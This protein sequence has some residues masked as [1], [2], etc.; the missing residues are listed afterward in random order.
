M[1]V[2]EP[3]ILVLSSVV[4]SFG[5]LT[6]PDPDTVRPLRSLTVTEY[7]IGLVVTIVVLGFVPRTSVSPETS[8]VSRGRRLS[9]AEMVSDSVPVC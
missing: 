5:A 4:A 9:S 7:V 8:L 1:I 6:V 2:P 3:L